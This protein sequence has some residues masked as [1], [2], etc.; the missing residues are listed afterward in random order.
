[1]VGTAYRTLDMRMW[2]EFALHQWI[3]FW[4]VGEGTVHFKVREIFF[5]L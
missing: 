4:I 3:W 5:T 1:M 2:E